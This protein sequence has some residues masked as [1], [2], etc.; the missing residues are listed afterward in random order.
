MPYFQYEIR[1]TNLENVIEFI[2]LIVFSNEI[3]NKT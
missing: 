1:F 3:R 2:L